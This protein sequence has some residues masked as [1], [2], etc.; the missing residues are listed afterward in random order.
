M[1]E[2]KCESHNCG[3]KLTMKASAALVAEVKAEMNEED[4]PIQDLLDNE[5]KKQD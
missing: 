3:C 5:D 4:K 1:T 2:E